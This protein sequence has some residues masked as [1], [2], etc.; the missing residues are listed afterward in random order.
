MKLYVDTNV[1]CISMGNQ[2]FVANM[3]ENVTILRFWI[4]DTVQKLNIRA[5][6][7]QVVKKV[8]KIESFG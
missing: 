4:S 7:P 5:P 2:I 1:N 8:G 6:K 3:S